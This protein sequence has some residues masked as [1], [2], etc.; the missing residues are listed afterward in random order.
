[1]MNQRL[2]G[3]L[4]D[5][6]GKILLPGLTMTIPLTAISF[7]LALIIAVAAALVQFANVRGLLREN[8]SGGAG[9]S[10]AVYKDV[11]RAAKTFRLTAH[12]MPHPRPPAATL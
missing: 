11:M 5:S 9:I 1:M 4:T 2:W 6:F 7:I 10:K 3:I 8:H 12:I